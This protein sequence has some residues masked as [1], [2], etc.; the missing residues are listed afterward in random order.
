MNEIFLHQN[1]YSNYPLEVLF[2]KAKKF[3]YDGV[4]LSILDK[5]IEEGIKNL[6]KLQEKYKIKIILHKPLKITEGEK[7]IENFEKFLQIVKKYIQLKII[8][9]MAGPVLIA[10]GAKYIEYWKNGSSIV[11][12]KDF[13]EA[14]EIF[15]NISKIAE[16]EK[17][18]LSIEIHGCLIHDTPETT[19]K[20]IKMIDS[21]FIGINFDYCNLYLRPEKYDIEEVLS[22]LRNHIFHSH[23]KNLR[24]IVDMPENGDLIF[25]FTSLKDGEIDYRYIISKLKKF[26]YKGPFTLEYP[27]NIGDPDI[28]ADKDIKYLKTLLK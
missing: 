24:K 17:I 1:C 11:T 27:G 9:T 13:I 22:S 23:L 18:F 7:E 14:S 2:K 25:F 8:N 16:K 26:N 6:S 15:K 19:L 12:E 21:P 28:I 3:G 4:E 5:N 10:K 20:L